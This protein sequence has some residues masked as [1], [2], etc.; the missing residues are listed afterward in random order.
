M[1][2]SRRARESEKHAVA[3][4]RIEPVETLTIR[5]EPAG[6]SETELL[7]EWETTRIRIPIRA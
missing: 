2:H 6:P 5:A 7:V 3:T 1:R 4:E